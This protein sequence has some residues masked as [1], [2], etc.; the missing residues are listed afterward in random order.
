M[1]IIVR[2][3]PTDDG[4]RGRMGTSRFVNGMSSHYMFR[5]DRRRGAAGLD[6]T[7]ESR[8][9]MAGRVRRGPLT[10]KRVRAR[11]RPAMQIGMI[12]L[13]RMGSNMVRRLTRG[14]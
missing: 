5:T 9:N 3:L 10:R 6:V 13:G 12:G 2:T 7:F 1:T 8:G 4:S 14:G 11:R